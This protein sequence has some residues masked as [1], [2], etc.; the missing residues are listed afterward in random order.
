MDGEGASGC[1]DVGG[2]MVGKI[3][4]ADEGRK[5]GGGWEVFSSI[6]EAEQSLV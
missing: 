6:D 1:W 3:T 5:S 4:G 2:E